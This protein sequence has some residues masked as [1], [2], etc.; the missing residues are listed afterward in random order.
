MTE[1]QGEWELSMKTV[2]KG[3]CR[4]SS[5]QVSV[6]S[7]Y[8]HRPVPV[9]RDHDHDHEH[10]HDHGSASHDHHHHHE[11]IASSECDTTHERLP[12]THSD[13]ERNF[14]NISRI[15]NNSSLPPTVK[16]NSLAVFKEIAIAEARIHGCSVDSIHFHEV[17]AIDSIIDTV[18]VILGFHLLG[19]TEVYCSALPLSSGTVFCQHGVLPV[20]APATLFLMQGMETTNAP[21][22][23]TGELVTPTAAAL[24]R[25]LCGFPSLDSGN[26]SDLQQSRQGGSAPKKLVVG[27][28]GYGAGTKEF[29]KHPNVLRIILGEIRG[30]ES[31]S[32]HSIQRSEIPIQMPLPVESAVLE[33]GIYRHYKDKLYSVL[34]VAKNTETEEGYVIYQA[35]YGEKSVWA[36]PL[37]MWLESVTLPSGE[38]V[39]RFRLE[40]VTPAVVEDKSPLNQKW[41]EQDLLIIQA[42]IDDMIPEIAGHFIDKA[43]AVGANDA[44]IENIV[45]K[46][47]R[48]AWTIN[49]LCKEKEKDNMIELV[50]RETTTIGV[51][52]VPIKRCSLSRSTESVQTQFGEIRFKL[53]SLGTE[54]ISAK[55]EFDDC[56][57]IAEDF[58]VPLRAV[59]D[60]AI[61]SRKL[62]SHDSMY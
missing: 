37:S 52:L 32:R 42:N 51:R 62:L 10:S 33:R 9:P 56:K 24:I 21:A 36:R 57:K 53:S 23:A 27:G 41:L 17:G 13:T 26:I 1:I 60:D 6:E 58:N 8:Q 2:L 16:E 34:G 5:K 46:K 35:M 22:G 25:V 28:I 39:P 49:I 14:E 18:G 3:S 31:Y 40:S 48:P 38:V 47:N 4:L 20:P 54:V 11:N 45:M 12:K 7:K 44:W 15:I 30:V 61:L 50:F 19:V 29:T 55:P 59:I 43:L